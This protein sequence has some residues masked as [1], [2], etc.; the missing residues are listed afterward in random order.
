MS[1]II[2]KIFFNKLTFSKKIEFNNYLMTLNNKILKGGNH[3]EV[4]LEFEDEESAKKF[5]YVFK[6]YMEKVK[7]IFA[8]YDEEGNIHL[9][10][11]TKLDFYG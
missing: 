7:G 4:L 3:N 5:M 6:K 11:K 1:K 9:K 8:Y 10:Y 2:R